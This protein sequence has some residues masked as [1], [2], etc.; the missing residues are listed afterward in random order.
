MA[1]PARVAAD[2]W[3][4]CAAAVPVPVT[5]KCRIGIDA[6]EEF[7]FLATFVATVAAAGCRTFIVHARK[8][9]LQGLSPKENREIPPL[10]H[11]VV[12][13]LKREFPELEVVLNGGLRSL[14]ARAAS[15]WRRS[16]A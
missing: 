7:G 4:R 1:E 5:V 6:S 2:A 16:T 3:R 8:A 14:A 13:R 15:S 11:E 9:W 10:R 12:M